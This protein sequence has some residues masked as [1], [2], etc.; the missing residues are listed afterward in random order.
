MVRTGME[1]PHRRFYLLESSGREVG[2]GACLFLSKALTNADYSGSNLKSGGGSRSQV[3]MNSF[4]QG[5]TV[6]LVVEQLRS[7]PLYP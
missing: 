3:Q 7:R 5:C 1:I 2:R 4:N 6:V